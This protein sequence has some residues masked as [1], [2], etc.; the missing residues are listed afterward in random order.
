MHLKGD[1]GGNDAKVSFE[2]LVG[3]D[4]WVEVVTK[5]KLGFANEAGNIYWRKGVFNWTIWEGIMGVDYE[6]EGQTT[7]GKRNREKKMKR[8]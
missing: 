8:Y 5:K 6:K 1:G 3:K 2:E 7:E 4:K